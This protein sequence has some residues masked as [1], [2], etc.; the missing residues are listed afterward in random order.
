MNAAAT[1]MF[2]NYLRFNL[3]NLLRSGTM[4]TE[5]LDQ[6]M[7]MIKEEAGGST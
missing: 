7:G 1:T 4:T 2:L 6:I 5:Q 3:I